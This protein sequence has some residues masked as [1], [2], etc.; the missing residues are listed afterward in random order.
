MTMYAFV[1]GP[2]V[3]ISILVCVLGTAYQVYRFYA[4][5][6]RKSAFT[7]P[8]PESAPPPG[9][10]PGQAPPAE[11]GDPPLTWGQRLKLG[12]LGT[13]PVTV[14]VTTVF[15][16]CLVLLPFF[17]LGHNVL[18]DMAWGASLP[19]L[20]EAAA[21][22]LTLVVIAGGLFFLGRR[23]FYP[24]VR[25]ITSAYDYVVLALA[26]TPF[27]TGFAA[28]HHLFHYDTVIFLHMLS[29]ELMLMAIPFTKLVHMP[30]FVLNR[31]VLV[32][33]NTF[34]RGGRR[35]WR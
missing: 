16:T 31:F 19:S 2:L 34:G 13:S 24:R 10:G 27:A 26:A 28:Y 6:R 9:P 35:V 8:P 23:L 17:V 5:S 32:H 20:P 18:L 4:L 7:L 15:H 11:A 30:F 1:R 25:A 33:E 21:D 12:I 22:F 14:V 29:G 3:W